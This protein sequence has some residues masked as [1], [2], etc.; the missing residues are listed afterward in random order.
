M[1]KAV[2]RARADPL[3]V[4]G[5]ELADDHPGAMTMSL[6]KASDGSGIVGRCSGS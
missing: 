4:A 1:G 5:A 6:T 3:S 2:L